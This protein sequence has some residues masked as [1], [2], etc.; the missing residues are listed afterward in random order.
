M[1]VSKF[2]AIDRMSWYCYLLLSDDGTRTYIGATIDPDRRLQQ[3]NGQKAGGAKAT[4]GRSW[5]RYALVEGFPDSTAALQ[6]EWAWK[7]QSRKF[8]HGLSARIKGLWALLDSPHS[9]SKARPFSEWPHPPVVL[10]AAK[11]L[12]P[13]ALPIAESVQNE[14]LLPSSQSTSVCPMAL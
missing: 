11:K 7:F 1:G 6:F 5:T 8:G 10:F 4:H 13:S 12:K 14:Y 9:T 3:H 2:F